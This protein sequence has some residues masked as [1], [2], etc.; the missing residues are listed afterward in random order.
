MCQYIDGVRMLK[1]PYFSEDPQQ[2]NSG[3]G[4]SFVEI[5]G[6]KTVPF[7]V[8]RIFY[9]YGVEEK[10]ARGKHANRRSRFVLISISGKCKVRVIDECAAET[11]YILDRPEFGLY[12]PEMVWKEMYEFSP[13]CVLMVLSSERYDAAE[14]IRDFDEFVQEVKKTQLI[15]KG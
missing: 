9:V 12:L 15:G 7:E 10:K 14:Y 8:R 11:E 2:N 5:T 1:F 13:D 4:Y 3:E 6:E